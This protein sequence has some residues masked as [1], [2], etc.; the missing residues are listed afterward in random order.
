MLRVVSQTR[1]DGQLHK[2]S[3]PGESGRGS[4]HV[5]PTHQSYSTATP[6]LPS[7]IHSLSFRTLFPSLSRSLVMETQQWLLDVV[8]KTLVHVVV[9]M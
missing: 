7:A 9:V 8:P 4:R 6:S 2:R 3:A 5:A 1:V